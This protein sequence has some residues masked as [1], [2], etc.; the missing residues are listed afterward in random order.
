LLLL[1]WALVLGLARGVVALPERCRP[2]TEGDAHAAAVEA[3]AWMERNQR[4][5]GRWVYR[6]DRE[7]DVVDLQSH[8]VRH[9]GVA[10]SLYQAHAVGIPGALDT[11][12][13]G[14]AWSFGELVRHDGWAAVRRDSE[15]PT[16]A[17]ALLVAGLSIR[18]AATGDGRFDDQMTELGRFLDAMTEPSGAVAARWDVP[19]RRPVPGEYSPFFTGEAYFALALLAEVDPAGGWGATAERV[20]RYLATERDDAED[21]FPPTSDHW[22]AYGLAQMGRGVGHALDDDE[23]A[24]AQ[25]L[26]G[27]F[28][29][30][31]RYESQR[32]GEGLNRWMLRG[33][34]A[35][36]AGVGTL[37]EGLGALWSLAQDPA[38]AA[39]GHALAAERDAIGERLRCVAGMLVDRQ[40]TAAGAAET[41]RPD[42]ARGA[43]FRMGVTQMDD[44][45][46][47]LSALL[48]ALP[49]L[50]EQES[51][52]APGVAGGSSGETSVARAAWLALVAVAAVNPARVRR[53]VGSV[54]TSP[55]GTG[56]AAGADST[57]VRALVAGAALS[58]AAFVTV[59]A[60]ARPLLD[61]ADVSATTGLVAAGL[62]VAL[63]AA[64]DAVH[65]PAP[66]PAAVPGPGSRWAPLAGMIVPV[67][68]PALVRPA[69][70][71]LV[72][73]VA[74]DAGLVTGLVVAAAAA[75]AGLVLLLGHGGAGRD[76]AGLDDPAAHDAEPVDGAPSA[77][78]HTADDPVAV[79]SLLAECAR[80]AFAALAIVGAVDLIAQG[81]L[82]V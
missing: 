49:A 74:V 45:Q 43:W 61:A 50:A 1:A 76:G 41:A 54:R 36:G 16:G 13:A 6:Y 65:R 63:A 20:G 23:I 75:A 9:S 15:A 10:M 14:V 38:G 78:G 71:L 70:A 68:V 62:V 18:K 37:G 17:T 21:R 56:R 5:D 24:Y 19:A 47:A 11:A 32:T 80:W 81:V 58:A 59:A 39:T 44:Q 51:G 52:A 33:P 72:V 2:V 40:V 46:H 79:P 4:P 7:D 48:L 12:D 27:I 53:I 26:A 8:V 82:G 35:L 22:A 30:Q 29:I 3:V 73:A 66:M 25:R 67:A 28:G 64:V 60:A 55:P 42:L 34:Q 31:V 77:A 69:V 57:G